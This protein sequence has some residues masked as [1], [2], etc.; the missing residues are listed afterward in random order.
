MA[1]GEPAGD[2]GGDITD[3]IASAM[4][5][6]IAN[7]VLT[8]ERIARG[9]GLNVVDLQTFGIILES[10]R[11]VTAGE[12]SSRTELPTSTT[13]RVIDRLEKIGF[14]RR[15]SDPADRRK[16]VVEAIPERLADFQDAYAPIVEGLRRLHE[17]FEP[18]EL[19]IIA[20]YLEAM[21]SPSASEGPGAMG[22]PGGDPAR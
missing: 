8:N 5:T 3:R 6:V 15:T 12:L 20:R 22:T 17:G 9:V 14:V 2:A 21:G 18:A 1:N 10:G 19:E 13:T 7:A 11:P 4:R 16:V